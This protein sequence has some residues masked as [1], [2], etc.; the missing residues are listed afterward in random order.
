MQSPLC[1]AGGLKNI[2][3]LLR[4]TKNKQKCETTQMNTNKKNT[5]YSTISANN[6]V[7]SLGG[8]S[9]KLLCTDKP[10]TM[11]G[12]LAALLK[13]ADAALIMQQLHY[14]LIKK[15][16]KI[17]DGIHWIYNTY[18]QWLDQMPWLS[19]WC[20]RK[21]LYKLRDMGLVKFAQLDKHEYKRRGYYTIDYQKL[22]ELAS[23]SIGTL[24]L[25]PHRSVECSH[26]DVQTTHTSLKQ[27]N[28]FQ[29]EL[30][31]NNTHPPHPVAASK[32]KE[33][34]EENQQN[35]TK[36][37][38]TEKTVEEK[39]Q[40][41]PKKHKNSDEDNFSARA[42]QQE[43]LDLIKSAEI[44]LNVQLAA[45]VRK[46]TLENVKN[47]IAHYQQTKR[48][49]AAQGKTID[50]PA[51]WLTDC[52]RQ[53]WW[54]QPTKQTTEDTEFSNWYTQAIAAGIVEDVPISWLVKNRNNEYLVRLPIPGPGGAPYSLISWRELPFLT[55][56]PDQTK[57]NTNNNDD[58]EEPH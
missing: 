4:Y 5:K 54:Q 8:I 30:P 42:E 26:I 58:F 48:Q 19:K 14:W 29:E 40:N 22:E 24:N 28:S 18:E 39:E 36:S 56:Q 51:G 23:S 43:K 12:G 52:L 6:S 11:S 7:N 57:E 15:G 10:R 44:R 16:G 2:G 45:L 21:I 32:K 1:E 47:A 53:N 17:I 35:V 33:E 46:F 50:R 41:Q 20:L 55:T 13:S 38:T 27:K 34:E 9:R 3:K 31:S 49:K 37:E 25:L